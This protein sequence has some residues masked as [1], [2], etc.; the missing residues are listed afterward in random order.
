MVF[1]KEDRLLK[2][3]A[4]FFGQ[5]FFD[6]LE[7][8]EKENN[9][10]Y[11]EMSCKKIKDI[12]S[13]ELI[14]SKYTSQ[15]MDFVYKMM[16]GSFVHYEYFSSNLTIDDVIRTGIN[17]MN[18]Y[19]KTKKLVNTI[20][21]ST[22]DPNKSVTNIKFSDENI[23]L[24]KKIKFL[25]NYEGDERLKN[26][27]IKIKDNNELIPFDILDLIMIPFFKMSKE[28]EE[29]LKEICKLVNEITNLSDEHSDIL[30]WGLWL[31][32]EIFIE[33]EDE[34]EKVRTMTLINGSSI[35]EIL[36]KKE[37][38]LTYKVKEEGREERNIEIAGN[39][40]NKGYALNEISEITG[41]NINSIKQLKL[42]K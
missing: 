18:L 25:K 17:D 14:T 24:P 4:Y 37:Y 16:D 36:H 7:M 28:P 31:T 1:H 2:E 33:D 8:L 40:L 11:K 29:V 21:I 10:N 32:S 23:Y 12:Y 5:H 22:G 38:E 30:F 3:L 19:K 27:E 26:V 6:Y 41:L 39:M 35:N 42:G 15:L 34:R 13:T 9:E 20:I